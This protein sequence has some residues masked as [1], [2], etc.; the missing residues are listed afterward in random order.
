MVYD[1]VQTVYDLDGIPFSREVFSAYVVKHHGAA[2]EDANELAKSVGLP[3]EGELGF[4]DSVALPRTYPLPFVLKHVR[5]SSQ[6]LPDEERNKY[7]EK[8]A[9]PCRQWFGAHWLA[10]FG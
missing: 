1:F 9:S 4:S 7:T 10:C 2:D 5:L 3:A 8:N 6:T